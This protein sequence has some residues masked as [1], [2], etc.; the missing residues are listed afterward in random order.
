ME[1]AKKYLTKWWLSCKDYIRINAQ[2]TK[3]KQSTG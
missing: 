3:T 2:F 1:K